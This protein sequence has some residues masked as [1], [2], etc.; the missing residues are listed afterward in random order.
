MALQQRAFS[1]HGKKDKER[2]GL[3]PDY[4]L[5]RPQMSSGPAINP[6]TVQTQAVRLFNKPALYDFRALRQSG[7]LIHAPGAI[8]DVKEDANSAQF[9]ISSWREKPYF[10]LINGLKSAPKIRINGQDVPLAAPHQF[11][12]EK[13]RLILQLQGKSAIEIALK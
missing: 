4:Y 2:V 8:S 9:K 10:V 5:L 7:L 13:G 11:N 1:T 3:L 12:A 6:G